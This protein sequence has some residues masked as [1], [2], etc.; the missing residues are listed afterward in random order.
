MCIRD[1]HRSANPSLSAYGSGGSVSPRLRLL[2]V[3]TAAQPIQLAGDPPPR[4]PRFRLIDLCACEH[5]VLHL[6]PQPMSFTSTRRQLRPIHHQLLFFISHEED[7]LIFFE[8]IYYRLFFHHSTLKGISAE[9]CCPSTLA[10]TTIRHTPVVVRVP[11]F[12]CQVMM[13]SALAVWGPRPA[14]W[15]GPLL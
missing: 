4:T 9:V 7:G 3:L 13:P 15:L 1:S 12:H 11:T 10:V 5:V 2:Q 14:A 8:P 6:D